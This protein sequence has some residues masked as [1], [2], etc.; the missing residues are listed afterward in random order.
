[1]TAEPQK[2]AGM[3]TGAKIL[4]GSAVAVG[5]TAAAIMMF[6]NVGATAGNVQVNFRFDSKHLL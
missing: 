2:H 4:A 1:M 6:G 3:G 5:A